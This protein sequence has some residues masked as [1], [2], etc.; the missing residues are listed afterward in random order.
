MTPNEQ[1]DEVIAFYTR[2]TEGKIPEDAA[3]L[4][5]IDFNKGLMVGSVKPEKPALSELR[6]EF[7]S[8]AE[9][10]HARRAEQLAAQQAQK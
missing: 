5:T 9:A 8:E 6:S 7:K 2:L 1:A 3:L 10:K 4:F